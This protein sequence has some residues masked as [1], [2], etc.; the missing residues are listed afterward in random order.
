MYH[1]LVIT[2]DALIPIS[3]PVLVSVSKK[4]YRCI[5]NYSNFCGVSV[6]G[7]NIIAD[8]TNGKA[9]MAACTLMLARAT[10][11]PCRLLA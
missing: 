7:R 9:V 6:T 1:K 3:V 5:T 8:V 4:W 11:H 10:C 2:S